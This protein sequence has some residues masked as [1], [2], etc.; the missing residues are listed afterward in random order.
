MLSLT[1]IDCCQEVLFSVNRHKYYV[2]SN[3]TITKTSLSNI[4]KKKKNNRQTI[5]R[6]KIKFR[7]KLY[8]ISIIVHNL[9]IIWILQLGF[10]EVIFFH[11]DKR[12]M[13]QNNHKN[14]K[15]FLTEIL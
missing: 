6:C 8:Y 2:Y 9:C 1:K 10:A 13:K 14:I 15:Y 11:I 5:Y 7:L 3:L 4:K 12:K